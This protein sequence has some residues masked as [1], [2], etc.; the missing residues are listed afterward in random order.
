MTHELKISPQELR[1]SAKVENLASV[2][3]FIE[4]ALEVV[5]CPMKTSITIQVAAEEIF[6]NIAHYAY[7]SDDENVGDVNIKLWFTEKSEANP[8]AVNIE[9]A[10]AG[11]PYNPLDNADPDIT[12][13]AE[14][15]DIGGLG[16]YM[17]KKSMDSVNYEYKDKLNILTIVK[18]IRLLH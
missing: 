17:V 9:F 8:L 1:I 10:D 12:L 5:D 6:V 13:S 7:D 14:E 16:V 4:G 15:R 11:K 2:L 3:E 18:N